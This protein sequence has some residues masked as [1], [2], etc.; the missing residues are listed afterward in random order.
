MLAG[1]AFDTVGPFATV[2][3]VQM[4]DFE[5]EAGSNA[6]F[7]LSQGLDTAMLYVYEGKLE[8]NG[9]PA[10][11][12]HIVL[13]DATTDV[14][15]GVEMTTIE[16]AKAVLFAGKKLKEPIAWHGPIV[17]NTQQQIQETFRELNSGQ[18]PPVRVEWDYKRLENE[19]KDA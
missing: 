5:M 11:E 1:E 19:P 13:F 2:Q 4:V 18:F 12:G 6:C 7:E 15:R 3:P 16:P 10:S 8:T 14:R 17:M 9:E